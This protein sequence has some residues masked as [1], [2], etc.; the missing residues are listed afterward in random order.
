MNRTKTFIIAVLIPLFILVGLTVKPAVTVLYGQEILLETRAVDPTDFFRGD[1][2]VVN[3]K[4]SEI[5]KT[6][7]PASIELLNGTEVYVLLKQEGPFHLVESISA[8]KPQKGLYLK[9]KIEYSFF[10]SDNVL[11]DYGLDKFFIKQGSGG[12][13]EEASFQG[14]LVA[15]VKVW[16]GYGLLTDVNLSTSL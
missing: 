10:D 9:G 7:F 3:P 12:K 6:E 16:N 13:L 11:I 8:A 5:P 15:N 1:Y 4:I 2:I 14:K